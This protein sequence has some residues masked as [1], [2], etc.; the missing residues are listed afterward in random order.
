M[1][2]RTVLALALAVVVTTSGCTALG[3]LAG[4]GDAAPPEEDVAAAFADL[5]TLSATQYSSLEYGNTTNHTRSSVRVAFGDPLRQYHRTLAPESRA[6]DVSTVNATA[7]VVYD[8]SANEVTRVPRTGPGRRDRGD[9]YASIVAAARTNGTVSTPS[10]GVSPLPV[11][12]ATNG[13]ASVPTED[14]EG[15]DVEYL[16]TDTV[17]GRTAHGF[18]MTPASPAAMEMNQTLWLDAEFY[19]PLET[20]QTVTLDNRT[21]HVHSRLEN[22]TFNADL[23]PDAF[24]FDPPEN[25]TVDTLDVTTETYGSLAETRAK[26]SLTVPSPDLPEGYAFD[27]AQSFQGNLTQLTVRYESADGAPLVVSKVHTESTN[28]SVGL[29]AGEQVTVAGHDATYLATAQSSLVAW[30]CE[31]VRYSVVAGD[32]DRQALLAVAASVSC[33]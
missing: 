3:S 7:T 28:G 26:S 33:E 18:R 17:A 27:S 29:D 19:F 10:Q 20:N 8:A 23:P 6:G 32:L 9:Y 30:S 11:V 13:G 22:V 14:I 21:Y 24:S 15:Y 5:E 16:G 25:A 2:R 1:V 12:P 4:G 31:G